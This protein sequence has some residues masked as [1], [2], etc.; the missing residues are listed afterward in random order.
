MTSDMLDRQLQEASRAVYG[1]PTPND[2]GEPLMAAEWLETGDARG[3]ISGK[4]PPHPRALNGYL[5][6]GRTLRYRARRK[7]R[8]KRGFK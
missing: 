1:L 7:G 5:G 8:S 2:H 6:K 3:F 4:R